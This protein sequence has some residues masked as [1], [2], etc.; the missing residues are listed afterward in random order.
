MAAV[1]FFHVPR[2]KLVADIAARFEDMRSRRFSCCRFLRLHSLTRAF[3]LDGLAAAR[4][5]HSGASPVTPKS[6]ASNPRPRAQIAPD[7]VA[8]RLTGAIFGAAYLTPARSLAASLTPHAPTAAAAPR[9][10]RRGLSSLG[11]LRFADWRP[12]A[13]SMGLRGKVCFP[14]QTRSRNCTVASL[15]S[16]ILRSRF[17]GCDPP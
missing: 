12:D 4:S 8:T 9:R 10:R 14:T 11:S 2:P 17:A 15:P 13:A 3:R 1:A 16:R 7:V 5:A 6:A